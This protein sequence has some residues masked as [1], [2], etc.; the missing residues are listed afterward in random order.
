MN[1]WFLTAMFLVAVRSTAQE[2]IPSSPKPEGKK[3]SVTIDVPS[4][5]I[6]RGQAYGG[7]FPAVQPSFDYTI[8]NRWYVGFWATTNFQKNYYHSDGSTKGYQEIDF[9]V[10]YKV[11]DFL[12]VELWDYY[13]PAFEKL[14]ETNKNYFNYGADGVK[15]VDFT[16]VLDFSEY[17]YPFHASISTLVAGNDYRYDGNGENPKQNY[18][19]YIEAG[20]SFEDVLAKLSEKTFRAISICPL[21]GAVLNNRAE[22]Y[23][24]ADYDKVSFINLSV[25]ANRE[26][27]LGKGFSMPVAVI[28]THNAADRNTGIDGRD[29]IVATVSLSY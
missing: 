10:G 11:C 22:Y 27:D 13:W 19:T 8:S 1:R 7:N 6:W 26:F 23:D 21:A 17:R 29:F 28:Y 3:W 4:R 25:S 20:Y 24:A 2:I 15:T 5:Y 14:E 18:T 12:S 16:V 9:G